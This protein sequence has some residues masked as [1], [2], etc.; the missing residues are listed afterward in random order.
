MSK[1]GPSR[2][3]PTAAH[4]GNYLIEVAD[5]NIV[6]VHDYADDKHASPI[7]QAFLDALD[8]NCRIDQPMVRQGYWRDRR[9]G[10]GAGRGREPFVAVSWDEALDL[11]AEA[12][13][14]VKQQYGNAAIYGGSYGW[15]SAGRFHH[16]QSQMHRFLKQ[17]GG[18]TESDRTYSAAAGEVLL[19]H[20]LGTDLYTLFL[21][22]PPWRDVV[23]HAELVVC[24][25][26]V[27]AKNLQVA[28]G[29]VGSHTAPAQ[30]RECGEAGVEVI[31]ISPL[32]SDVPDEVNARWISIRP[33]TD[34]ALILAWC[35]IAIEE[36]LI[37]VAFIERY[38]V[39]FAEFR[40]YLSGARD[41]QPKDADWAA[42]I[43]TIPAAMIRQL[44]RRIAPPRG[45]PRSAPPGR[46]CRAAAASR[47]RRP[48]SGR[49]CRTRCRRCR[50]CPRRR[51]RR[52]RR[53]ARAPCRLSGGSSR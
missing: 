20:V 34:A 46:G 22:T 24:F 16:A 49:G 19:P 21:H 45:T 25:G 18:Y 12:L 40:D 53:S 47:A 31:N 52:R 51:S 33:N 35:A 11:A 42:A 30:M 48:R 32:R 43:T 1:H 23:A 28:M 4:W 27:P 41:G 39:G 13:A 3:I 5:D 17:F 9:A 6:A 44:A 15:A 8:P 37:D 2:L 50:P 29:G 7:G 38:T 26:G 10:N 14:A 36:A